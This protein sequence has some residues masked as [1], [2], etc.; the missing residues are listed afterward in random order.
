MQYLSG[1]L[2]TIGAIGLVVFYANFYVAPNCFDGISNGEERGADCGGG[3][4]QICQ[5]DVIPPIVVWTESFLINEGQY[6]V[7]AYVEN[8]N[9]SIGTPDLGYTFQL[10]SNGKVIG[11][12]SGVT[13]LP[14][15][16]IYPV[17]EGRVFTDSNQKVTDT[18]I[19]INSPASWLPSSVG[20]DQFRTLDINLTSAD[21]RPRLNVQLENTTLDKATGVEVVATIFND[22]GD[23]VTS[24]QTFVES[25]EAR[26]TR[27]IVFTWPNPI[28]KTVRNCV[29]PTDVA[30]AIDLSGSMNND[31]ENP[32]QPVTSAL[33][34][35][36]QFV[37]NLRD[38]D[39]VAVVTFAS[40]A[41]LAN[42]L[43]N[44]R[45]QVATG[46][47]DL[48]INPKEE[49]GF[50]NTASALTLA[51][52]ELSS[53][54][55]NESARRVLVLLTDGLP[56]A[57]GNDEFVLETE[58]IAREIKSSGVEIYA[59]GLGENVDQAF[60]EAVASGNQNAYLAP[61]GTELNRIYSEITSSLCEVGP[62]KIDVVAKTKA[63]FA[64]LQ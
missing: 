18:R 57:R 5:A 61:T 62:T 39:Q 32:P 64:P 41:L 4:V 25:I 24:S 12:R 22:A 54:R 14:P 55:H 43:T 30:L 38:N 1:F 40:E 37:G 52:A 58:A 59:I 63:N 47:T 34:S 26:S 42:Q 45:S 3:C 15:N 2:L 33:R 35:A 20:R 50:T 60:I 31:G 19:V 9:Q 56:T 28:A 49:T 27:E 21:S 44:Q 10:L 11:E 16:S 36:S 53:G 8:Q 7:V 51:D 46:I 6:N 17:F 23:P 13:A 48:V 29:I